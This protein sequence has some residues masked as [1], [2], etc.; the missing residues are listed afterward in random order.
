MGRESRARGVNHPDP[1][2]EPYAS[3]VEW[4]ESSPGLISSDLAIATLMVRV[5]M[6]SNV[7]STHLA[8]A[9]AWFSEPEGAV[10]VGRVVVTLVNSAAATHEALQLAR[11]GMPHL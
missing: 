7:L 8:A 10:R 2:N 9:R 6:A 1:P 5:G 3:S 11:E 4:Y